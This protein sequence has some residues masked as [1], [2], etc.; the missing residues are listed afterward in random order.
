MNWLLPSALTTAGA[1]SLAI[2][3]LHFIARSRPQAE[4]LPTARFIPDRP[5]RAR[6][7]ALALSDVLLLLLRVAAILTLGAAVAGPVP[8]AA[9]GRVARV[10]AVDRSRS[11]GR[12]AELRDSVRA[13]ARPGD[14]IVAFDTGV[15]L[16]SGLAGL[17]SLRLTDAPGALST[18]LT[19]TIAAA[20]RVGSSADSLELVLVSPFAAD[21]R[22]A[23]TLHIRESWPGRLRLVPV[24]IAPVPPAS[25]RVDVAGTSDDPVVAASALAGRR[26]PTGSDMRAATRV[27]RG[28]L[29]AA[30]SAWAR[31]PGHLLVHW[32]AD[33]RGADWAP[34]D[35]M[36]T[37]YAV[38][39]SGAVVV[40]RFP[41]RWSLAG[42]ASARWI[43]GAPAAVENATGRGCIRDVA[44]AVDATSDLAVRPPFRALLDAMLA[45]CGGSRSAALLDAPTLT[46]LGGGGPLVAASALPGGTGRVSP[47][48]PWLLLVGAAMLIGELAM[49][50]A[51]R[52]DR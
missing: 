1:A 31:E 19:L 18:A 45:P 7:R 34:R 29:L 4:S 52:L 37:A 48:T 30:D 47:Y 24:G 14:V 13:L 43:D 22:D 51:R 39:A 41:R 2:V 16:V 27:A 38:T 6:A 36:D 50:R 17:D 10:I 12:V 8:A 23:A 42:A 15:A 32:P 35:P 25:P 5:V 44:I 46:A 26:T 11:V 20:R 3:A 33:A 40:G 21:E 9:R 49:R 28:P